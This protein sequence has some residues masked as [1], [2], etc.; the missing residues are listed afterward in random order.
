M[1]GEGAMLRTRQLQP[2]AIDLFTE[3]MRTWSDQRTN[4]GL[5]TLYSDVE[6]IDKK[7][8]VFDQIMGDVEVDSALKRA[9]IESLL[10]QSP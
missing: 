4:S 7:E 5:L 6:P 10:E 8:K 2:Q 9:L 1:T 3:R